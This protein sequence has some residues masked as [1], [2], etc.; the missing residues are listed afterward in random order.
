MQDYSY[1]A[2]RSSAVLTGSY[3]GGTVLGTPGTVPLQSYLLNQVVIY[4]DLTLGNL[5][6]AEVKVEFSNDNSDFYQET[7]VAI[8][9]GVAGTSLLAYTFTASGKYRIPVPVKDKYIRISAKGTG[10][11][12]NSL[13]AVNAIVGIA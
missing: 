3:V 4:I 11:V 2:V 10:D 5:T 13:M 6:S 12:T 9:G 1:Q 7:A 8:S